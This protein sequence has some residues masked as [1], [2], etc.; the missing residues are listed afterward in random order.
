M[1]S[2]AYSDR[3]ATY[4]QRPSCFAAARSGSAGAGGCCRALGECG[5][6]A[7]RRHVSSTDFEMDRAEA[8]R[9]QNLAIEQNEL[10]IWVVSWGTSDFGDQFVARPFLSFA[11]R[12]MQRHIKA[13]T[14]DG[15]RKLLPA[16]LARL[17]PHPGDDP[18][19]VEVWL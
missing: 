10:L 12:P 9:T 6:M 17:E 14:L 11:G 8:Q 4:R 5:T 3:V 1:A 15:C 19:I 16:G 13:A 2:G 18:V 7:K